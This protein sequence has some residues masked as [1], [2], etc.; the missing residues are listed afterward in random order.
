MKTK[1]KYIVCFL[2]TVLIIGTMGNWNGKA[3][4][5]NLTG[6]NDSFS[7]MVGLGEV[8]QGEKEDIAPIEN[9]NNV[10]KRKGRTSPTGWSSG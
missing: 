2:T 9:L 7:Q 4:A 10:Q 1:V 3:L 5:K 6:V 8:T